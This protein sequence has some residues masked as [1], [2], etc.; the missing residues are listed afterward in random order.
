LLVALTGLLAAEDRPHAAGLH[1]EAVLEPVVLESVGL[2]LYGQLSSHDRV[3]VGCAGSAAAPVGEL[4]ALVR[5]QAALSSAGPLPETWSRAVAD[6]TPRPSSGLVWMRLGDDPV[7]GAHTT[8]NPTPLALADRWTAHW[9]ESPRIRAL[10]DHTVWVAP[11]GRTPAPTQVV[12][13]P[14]LVAEPLPAEGCVAWSRLVDRSARP[15][16]RLVAL[17]DSH[18]L[19]RVFAASARASDGTPRVAA[20]GFTPATRRRPEAVMVVYAAPH[21]VSGAPWL[22]HSELPERLSGLS[23]L[24]P[25]GYTPAPGQ[26]RAWFDDVVGAAVAV[27]LPVVDEDGEP[28]RVRT[29]LIDVRDHYGM[30][31]EVE[32]EGRGGRLSQVGGV[33]I[34]AVPGALVLSTDPDILVDILNGSGREW[35]RPP[36]RAGAVA[37]W[38]LAASDERPAAG[39]T[40]SI[41]D[42]TWRVD[43]AGGLT[44]LERVLRWG[45]L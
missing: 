26:V 11:H 16:E 20:W 25:S 13:E 44:A 17:D 4:V 15:V 30:S 5:G 29:L 8:G 19:L 3:A 33:T 22:Q 37:A 14:A 39:A 24:I 41:E 38:W 34:G 7:V 35:T 9:T 40:L 12:P 36:D 28:A 27:V 6:S 43:A 23:S 10:A 18:A 31:G 42:Q 45:G 21:V 1:P 32:P 2:R